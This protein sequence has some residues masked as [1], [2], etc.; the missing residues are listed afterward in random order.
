MTAPGEHHDRA[1]AR[2]L[3]HGF[4]AA[5]GT[6]RG[7]T[8]VARDALTVF[9]V[10]GGT[11][12]VYN[13][14]APHATYPPI[15]MAALLGLLP[16][17]FG[18]IHAWPRR[19]LTRRLRHPDVT[20]T[21]TV[22]DVLDQDTHVVIGYTDTFDTNVTDHRIIHPTSLQAQFQCRYYPDTGI[23]DRALARTLE[24]VPSRPTPTKYLGKTQRYPIGTIAVLPAGNHLAF[25]LAYATMDDELLAK[26]T[27][28]D[29]W[30]SLT[31]LWDAVHR[32]AHREPVS[33]A[34]IGSQLAKV[35]ALDRG[36]L[37]RLIM[38]SFVARTRTQAVT[39]HLTVVVHPKDIGMIDMPE[40]AALLSTV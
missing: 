39:R 5:L 23:L 35:D 22:G 15:V 8:T 12:Q 4:R 27:V 1:T 9:G 24:Q 31:A 17:A 16:L 7:L 29:I 10:V 20:I 32:H 40:L 21:V 26:A 2:R 19:T 6:R 14:L 33:I 37:I 28:D 34:V 38:L 13:I 30:S 36:S 18:L 3:L 25:C 11:L